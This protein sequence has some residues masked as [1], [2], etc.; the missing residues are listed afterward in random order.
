MKKLISNQISPNFTYTDSLYVF[1][2]F[3]R[4]WSKSSLDFR[5]FFKTENYLLTNA[6]RTALSKI[7]ETAHFSKEKKIGIPAFC[8]VVMATPFLEKGYAIQWIDTDENGVIDVE[9]FLQKSDNMS[10]VLVP[11]VFGQMAPLGRIWEIAK[12]KNIMVI[13]DCAHAFHFDQSYCDVQIWSFGREK[14]ISCVSGGALVWSESSRM[15]GFQ[16]SLFPLEKREI[17]RLLLQPVIFALVLP[18]WHLGS[19]GKIVAYIMRRLRILPRAVTEKEKQ[20]RE[21]FPQAQLATPLQYILKYKM[22]RYAQRQKHRVRIAKKWKFVLSDILPDA[23]IIIP[24]NAFRVIVKT[25]KA[26]DIKT[27]ARRWG[28]DL[29]EWEGVPIS[30]ADVHLSSIGYEEGSCVNAEYFARHY[31][32]FPTNIRTTEKDVENF[33]HQW[34]LFYA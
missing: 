33:R 2:Q 1:F 18:V 4:L 27:Q 13:E 31:V 12:R 25:E 7:I 34:K 29:Y 10:C 24:E 3:F 32:T 28:Y 16:F 11:H 15:G 9:D 5:S 8:C 23:E 20:G 22:R 19:L 14:V 17:L 21:D 30:P 6:A 26:A